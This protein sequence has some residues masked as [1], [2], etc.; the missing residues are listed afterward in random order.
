MEGDDGNFGAAVEAHS[1]SGGPDA[2]TGVL[3]EIVDFILTH[4]VFVA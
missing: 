3:D 2:P 4:G 1:D